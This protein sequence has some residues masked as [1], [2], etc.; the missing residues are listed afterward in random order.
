MAA[1]KVRSGPTRTLQFEAGGGEFLSQSIF[2]ALGALREG[3]VAQFL[4]EIFFEAA[5][6]AFISVDRHG[7]RNR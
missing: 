1:G 2:T 3:L 4:K 5:V 7:I 6:R